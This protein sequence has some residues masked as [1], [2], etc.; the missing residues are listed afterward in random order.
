[1]YYHILIIKYKFSDFDINGGGSITY[2][3]EK[4]SLIPKINK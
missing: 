1:M 2:I 3:F 4:N